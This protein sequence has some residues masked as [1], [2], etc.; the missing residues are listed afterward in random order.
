MT[1]L[2]TH[3]ILENSY[4]L[5]KALVTLSIEKV[6]LDIG[7]PVYDLVLER[8]EADKI[9]IPDLCEKPEYLKNLLEELFGSSYTE[10][11]KTIKTYLDEFSNRNQIKSFINSLN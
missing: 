6:L 11:I 9:T 7:K 5:E 2:V 10:I 1:K 8:L 3:E 4:D